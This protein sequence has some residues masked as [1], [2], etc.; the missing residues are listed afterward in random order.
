V[1]ADSA[2]GSRAARPF[3]DQTRGFN[4]PRTA[5]WKSR[6][7][8]VGICSR[9]L[10][11]APVQG[12]FD[13]LAAGGFLSQRF[14]LLLELPRLLEQPLVLPLQLGLRA[15]ELALVVRD[16]G[17]EFLQLSLDAA[18]YVPVKSKESV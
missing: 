5:A 8:V 16:V 1:A 7:E 10:L 9:E 18:D 6:G 4:I 3:P 13:G 2:N 12:G 17:S 11:V 15:L 14:R